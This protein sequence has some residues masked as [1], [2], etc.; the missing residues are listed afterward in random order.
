V[1]VEAEVPVEVDFHLRAVG[2]GH[3]DLVAVSR[4]VG[5]DVAGLATA[6]RLQRGRLGLGGVGAGDRLLQRL[7][8]GGA[9]SGIART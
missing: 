1:V 2:L 7:V 4:D 6:D 5:A 3:H 9:V 8:R